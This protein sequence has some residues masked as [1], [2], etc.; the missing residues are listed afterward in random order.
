MSNLFVVAY[1]LSLEPDDRDRQKIRDEID[2]YCVECS[3][4]QLSESCYYFSSEKSI[5]T[6]L[7]D[8]SAFTDSTDVISVVTVA[9]IRTNSACVSSKKYQDNLAELQSAIKKSQT[10]TA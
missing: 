10:R 8:V 7:S 4:C 6:I 9:D 5:D 2:G 3:A 1:E